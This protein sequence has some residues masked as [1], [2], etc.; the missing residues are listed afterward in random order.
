MLIFYG[1]VSNEIFKI[2]LYE[3]KNIYMQILLKSFLLSFVSD[4]NQSI[5]TLE[6]KMVVAQT[7]NQELNIRLESRLEGNQCVASKHRLVLLSH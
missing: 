3:R 6:G 4:V 2:L 7:T 5:S 1:D